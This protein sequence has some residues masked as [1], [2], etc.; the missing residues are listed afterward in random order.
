MDM[1]IGF[2]G[3]IAVGYFLPGPTAA[4]VAWVKSLFNKE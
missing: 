3:G 4:L 2:A 1:L